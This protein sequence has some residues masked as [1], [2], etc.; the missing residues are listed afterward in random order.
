MTAVSGGT[1]RRHQGRSDGLESLREQHDDT[2]P[3]DHMNKRH[4]ITL[5][6]GG[7]LDATHVDELVTKLLLLGGPPEGW[8]TV[9]LASFTNR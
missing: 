8:T 9:D 7:I 2:S 3:A 5:H 4:W 1:L 6:P